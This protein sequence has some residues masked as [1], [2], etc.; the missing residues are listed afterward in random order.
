MVMKIKKIELLSFIFSLCA[1]VDLLSFMGFRLA[2]TPMLAYGAFLLLRKGTLNVNL[3]IVLAFFLSCFPSVLASF[4]IG[5]SMGYMVWII[6]NFLFISCVFKHLAEVD[7]YSTIKGVINS[8]RVQII[9]GALFYFVHLQDRAHFLY[10]EPSYFAIALIPYVIMVLCSVLQ[11]DS[12]VI[13]PSISLMDFFLCLVAIYTTKS[14][15]LLLVFLIGFCVISLHGR[16]KFIKVSA[17]LFILALAFIFLYY[18]AQQND[19]LIAM[20]FK[21]IFMSGDIVDG[22]RDRAGNRWYRFEM[23][24]KIATEHFWGVGIGAYIEYTLSNM[25]L[26]PQYSQLPWYLNPIGLPV[27]NLYIEMA[28]TCGWLA[29]VIWLF[30]H[31]RL[32]FSRKV[33]LF[34]GTVIYYSLLVSMIILIT[35]SSFMRPYYWILIGIC[36][37][38]NSSVF[39]K[40]RK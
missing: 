2:L 9:A 29:L 32:L 16:K 27:I 40:L 13:T 37:S 22:L 34:K 3:F 19:D 36:M 4:A 15:N 8:Y 10:Y 14:A 21:N 12:I 26:Y 25:S 28:A 5:T 31:Y 1:S 30:W 7:Y 35:E 23:A 20:T 17:S 24:Y 39:N 33:R 18:Y 38:H 11:K 6:F